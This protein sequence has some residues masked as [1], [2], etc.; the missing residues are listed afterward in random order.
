MG[1][2]TTDPGEV[3]PAEEG[4]RSPFRRQELAFV[5]AMGI[6]AVLGRDNP[7]VVYPQVL[8]AFE[9]LF[10]FNLLYHYLLRRFG[11]RWEIALP[12]L[13]GNVALITA[14]LYFTGGADSYYWPMYLL[15]IFSACLYLELRH[16]WLA[17]AASAAFLGYFYID[18]IWELAPWEC[19]AAFVKIAV[20]ALSAAVTTRVAFQER[21]HRLHLKAKRLEIE[22]L[23]HALDRKE[24]FDLEG[25]KMRTLGQLA[26]GILHNLNGP[27]TVILGSA[28]L[29]LDDAPADS[30]T[31]E[32]LQRIMT[33]ANA[34]GRLTQNLLYCLRANPLAVEEADVGAILRQAVNHFDYQLKSCN[35]SLSEE[36]PENLP[37]VK[38]S[39]VCLQLTLFDL[40]HRASRSSAGGSR[41]EVKAFLEPEGVGITIAASCQEGARADAGLEGCRELLSYGGGWL[42]SR[43][44]GG[45]LEYRIHLRQ[46]AG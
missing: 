33:A 36:I 46:G 6:V 9:A 12:S 20:L 25:A 2:K 23:A 39:P 29:M 34:C 31:R 24:E 45:G 28:S 37:K 16:V 38:L 8:W 4:G 42:D 40:L 26:A 11:G 1:M 41:L 21:R 43:T 13:A 19:L 22:R 10:V 32:D 3:L 30:L 17:L 44:T 35:L 7:D 5:I 27:L 14:I 18:S 15:P